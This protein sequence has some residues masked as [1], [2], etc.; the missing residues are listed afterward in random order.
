MMTPTRLMMMH[1]T[2]SLSTEAVV[3]VTHITV[4]LTAGDCA[5]PGV[6]PA[7]AAQRCQLPPCTPRS[8]HN[9]CPQSVVGGQR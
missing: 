4:V 2:T 1:T 9:D 3:S 8:R 6:R 7:P 5:Q